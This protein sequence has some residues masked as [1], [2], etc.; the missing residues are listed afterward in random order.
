MA[1]SNNDTIAT[2]NL[3]SFAF[4]NSFT[5]LTKSTPAV[6][7]HLHITRLVIFNAFNNLTNTTY[8]GISITLALFTT[9]MQSFQQSRTNKPYTQYRANSP[10]HHLYPEWY[11]GKRT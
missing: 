5:I 8:Q 4:S 6:T 1:N 11:S 3:H 9:P 7:I 10:Y 2:N